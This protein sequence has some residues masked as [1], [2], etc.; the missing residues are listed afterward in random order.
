MQLAILSSVKCNLLNKKYLFKPCGEDITFTLSPILKA[1]ISTSKLCKS[2]A[3]NS[4]DTVLLIV[5]FKYAFPFARRVLAT[6]TSSN[7][8]VFSITPNNA[9]AEL[10]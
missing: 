4:I 5:S 8:T 2:D 6:V 9:T 3:F 10:S 1:S 7:I